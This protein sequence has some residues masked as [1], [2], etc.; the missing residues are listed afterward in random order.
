MKPSESGGK[1][2]KDL[3]DPNG[4]FVVLVFL[5]LCGGMDRGDHN[6]LSTSWEARP[7]PTSPSRFPSFPRAYAAR[8]LPGRHSA[9]SRVFRVMRA[10]DRSPFRRLYGIG[11]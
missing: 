1:D 4:F 10:C 6:P 2:E 5:V 7:L 8:P 11:R 3:K 9:P